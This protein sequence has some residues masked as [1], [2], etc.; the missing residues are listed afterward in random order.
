[1]HDRTILGQA[2]TGDDFIFPIQRQPFFVFVVKRIKEVEQIARIKLRCIAGQTARHIFM[3][4]QLDA[5]MLRH[6]TGFRQFAIAALLDRKVN[7][8]RAGLHA[9]QHFL[10]H[11]F[12]CRT[13]GNKRGTDDNILLGDMFGYQSGLTLLIIGTHF[14]RITAVRLATFAL[15]G[16]DHDKCTTKAFHLFGSGAAHIR[17]RHNRTQTLGGCNGLQTRNA[18]AHHEDTRGRNRTRC[19]HHHWQGTTILCCCVQNRLIA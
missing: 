6:L 18:C 13:A 10:G 11:Q 7:Q 14:F 15:I 3:R 4:D 19:R 16:F 1:M 8:N 5:F 9:F 2:D 12:R 17:G